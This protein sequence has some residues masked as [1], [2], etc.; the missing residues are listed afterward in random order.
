M[1]LFILT[2]TKN[3][4]QMT[5]NTHVS[6][7]IKSNIKPLIDMIYLRTVNNQCL[8]IYSNVCLALWTLSILT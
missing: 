1:L 4:F 6:E 7:D 2:D 8:A 5:I 3:R